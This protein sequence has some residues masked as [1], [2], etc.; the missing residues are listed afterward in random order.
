MCS[1]H[2]TL[3]GG[4]TFTELPHGF[5]VQFKQFAGLIPG[6]SKVLQPIAEIVDGAIPGAKYETIQDVLSNK[7]S[8]KGRGRP[9]KF[10]VVNIR[11][12]TY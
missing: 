4:S 8:G 6:V 10:K 7:P 9:K 11:C 5:M 1:H 3:T 2:Q 12:S